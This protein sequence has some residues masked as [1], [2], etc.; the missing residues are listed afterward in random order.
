MSTPTIDTTDTLRLSG[1]DEAAV[2]AWSAA[3][4]DPEWLRQRRLEALTALSK[5]DRPTNRDEA[6]RFTD[7]KR[8]GLDRQPIVRT[9]GP[10]AAA[11]S[12][13][14][15][16]RGVGGGTG[17]GVL[18]GSDE[19]RPAGLVTTVDGA[20]T[21]AALDQELAAKGVILT[22]LLTA[23][24][25][26]PGLVEP[27]FMTTAA[28][29]AE[30]W[31][32]ALH[33][34][35][36][37]AGTFLYVPAGVEVEVPLGAA[38]QRTAGGATFAHTLVVVEPGAS[39]VFVQQHDSPP[40]LDAKAFHHGIT[41]VFVGADARVQ[42]LSLQEWGSEAVT[43]FSTI[44]TEN[45]ERANFR[46]FVISL[47]GGTVRVAPETRMYKRSEA[48]LLGAAFA[49]GAQR[50]EHRTTT[51]HV[52]PMARSELLFKGGLL[53]RSRN[54]LYGNVVIHPG[55]RGSDANQTMRNLVLSKQAHAE[56]IPFLEIENSDVRCGHAAATGRLDELHLFYLQSRGIPREEARR[57]AV[58]GFFDEI[59]AQVTVEPVRRR[60][61]A[62]LEAELAREVGA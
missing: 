7:P 31:F 36:V 11:G 32:S 57:M 8:A 37:S 20:A 5:H 18:G 35:V 48:D 55:A 22:D 62:A 61:E 29:F 28:P 53:E 6:W 59:L 21:S 13:S 41:E 4:G 2:S 49:D 17:A 47:G 33:A 3:L 60:L 23:A 54:I 27:R 38:Y 9:A 30:D 40:D 15:D 46:S 45:G 12:A 42:F 43:H 50:F 39:L 25:E 51:H 19:L 10:P 1:L 24:R 56:A 44:R 26:H 16:Q 34:T 58:F 14:S 52:E